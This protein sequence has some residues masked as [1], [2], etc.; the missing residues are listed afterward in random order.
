MTQGV[1]RKQVTK[2]SSVADSDAGHTLVK[3]FARIL[4]GFFM[5]EERCTGGAMT[6][7]SLCHLTALYLPEYHAALL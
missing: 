5:P 4:A 1:K 3:L 6:G 7:L 2:I